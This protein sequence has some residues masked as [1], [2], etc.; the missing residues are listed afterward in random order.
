MKNEIVET[1][2]ARLWWADDGIFWV[3]ILPNVEVDAPDIDEVFQSRLQLTGHTSVPIYTDLRA[4]RSATRKALLRSGHTDVQAG[5]TAIGVSI[6][7]PVSRFVGTFFM[8]L[9]RLPY[10]FKI[11]TSEE[12]AL[13]WLKDFID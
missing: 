7:S 9:S 1:R 6:S 13:N 11:F 4:I 3:V 8:R 5:I 12:E 2:V 10:P